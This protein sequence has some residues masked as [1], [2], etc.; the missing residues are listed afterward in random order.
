VERKSSVRP[1]FRQ[2]YRSTGIERPE[3]NREIYGQFIFSEEL[4][5]QLKKKKKKSFN[6]WCEIH[7]PKE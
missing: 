6:K 7:M 4:T 3:I 1:A 2:T 5:V